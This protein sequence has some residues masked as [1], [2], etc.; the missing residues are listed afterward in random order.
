MGTKPRGRPQRL[1]EKLRQIRDALG[2]SQSE[3]V[4]RLG[5]ENS[6]TSAR[7]SEYESDMREPSLFTLL[8]Y[9]R[10]A[11]VHLEEIIDDEL[12]LPRKLPGT[13][14]YEAATRKIRKSQG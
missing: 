3:M 9:A 5:V 7:I 6:F 11:Q 12:D 13:F 4:R 2:L 8:A 14:D 1:G 10:V